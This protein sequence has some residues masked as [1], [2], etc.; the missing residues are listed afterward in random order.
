MQAAVYRGRGHIA[1]EEWPDSTPGPGELLVRVRSCGLCG[2]D[3]LKIVEGKLPP[4]AVF[5]H[6]ISGDVAAVGDNVT[7]F[8]PGDRVVVSHHVP[9]YNCHY[10][11]HEN[12]SMCRFFKATNLHPGGFAQYVRV[13]EPNVRL[14]TFHLPASLSY[15]QGSFMEP[16][17]CCLRS[18]KKGRL[19]VGD[20]VVIIG[21]GSIG[22]LMSQLVSQ[23]FQAK[24]VV[25]DLLEERL[26]LAEHLGAD[27]TF[28]AKD[29]SLKD[30]I[31]A[32][33]EGRGADLIIYTAGQ[34]E[35]VIQAL[36][37]IRDGGM[38]N[39]FASV[40][41]AALL[42]FRALYFREITLYGSYSPSPLDLAQALKLL[43]LGKVKGDPL[44]SHHFSLAELAQAV[45]WTQQKKVLKAI[46]HP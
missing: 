8:R 44:I 13:P 37:W 34:G 21:S 46:I 22:L 14:A 5:G 30:G 20:V 38:I 9:C 3:I 23:V 28:Q 2:S 6:E 32:L 17:A 12:F 31:H 24:A 33:T 16:L 26:A 35:T 7:A 40:A 19:Q 4:P 39:L 18:L 15:D 10:C 1:V 42:D 25:V 45:E 36:E 41:P 27:K 43:D 11:R 29:P